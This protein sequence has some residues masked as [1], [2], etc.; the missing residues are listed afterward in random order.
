M[1][2]PRRNS[3]NPKRRIADLSALTDDEREALAQ[4]VQYVGSG[5]HK[6]HPADYGLG[7]VDPRPEKS[8]CDLLRPI[9]KAEAQ[10]LLQAGV[11]KGMVSWPLVE[12]FPKYIWSVSEHGEAF[13]AKTHPNTPGQYHGYPLGDDDDMQATVLHTWKTRT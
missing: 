5:N 3:A 9:R 11:R 7:R 13:E 1:P 10:A 2:P 12:G 8:L 4:Q 6:R